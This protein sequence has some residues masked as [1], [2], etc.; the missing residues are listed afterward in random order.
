MRQARNSLPRVSR[1]KFE[2]PNHNRREERLRSKLTV[3]KF[4]GSGATATDEET[5]LLGQS[6]STEIP[7][8]SYVSRLLGE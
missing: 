1:T 8:N 4:E 2:R 3:Q 6:R 7:A 5:P